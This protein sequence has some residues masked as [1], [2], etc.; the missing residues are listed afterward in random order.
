MKIVVASA[1]RNMS[2]RISHYFR[3]VHALQE[4]LGSEH[5]VRVVACEGDSIDDTDREIKHLGDLW[6][7]PTKVITHNHGHPPFG[8]TE[9]PERLKAL[10]G[11]SN[12]VFSGV[13]AS[14]D[15]LVYVES[16]L[17]WK[18][19]D[20]GSLIDMARDR[21]DGFDVFAPMVWAGQAFY[22][23][24]GFRG[25][26]GERF[27]PFKPFHPDLPAQGIG[28]IG[29]AGSCLVMKAGVARKVKNE[30]D[31]ALVGWCA[32]ARKEKYKIACAVGFGIKHPA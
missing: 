15:V 14:D 31:M 4:H 28:E 9:K 7:I 8:S 25:L 19:H 32:E 22:D 6:E 17:I 11:V 26:D 29:S 13:R 1:F 12:K 3:Q 18:P 5:A 27:S 16:D 24:W 20:I 2:G 21:R 10:T 23:I 30:S